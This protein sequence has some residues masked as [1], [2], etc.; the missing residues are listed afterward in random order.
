MRFNSLFLSLVLFAKL[1]PTQAQA[2]NANP[3]LRVIKNRDFFSTTAEFDFKNDGVSTDKVIRTGG[4]S[5]RYFYDLFDADHNFQARGITR[6]LS[7]GA[8]YSW[9]V[10]IDLYD[11]RESYIGLI[12]GEI[13][14][15][16]RAKFSFYNGQG[17]RTLIGYLN[18][19]TPEFL[20]VSA[21]DPGTL[22]AKLRIDNY[23]D[24]GSVEVGLIQASENI[25]ERA[26]KIFS[27]FVADYS[28]EFLPP[29]KVINNTVV[30]YTPQNN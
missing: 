18:T 17:R 9:G 24:V 3:S 23:G 21:Q 4:L 26:F 1:L 25:D 28:M 6:A 10:E 30:I 19:E 15:S 11:A 12:Q 14:T 27:A 20:I 29:P 7:L 22:L 5:P 2:D 8:L 16:S 13:L